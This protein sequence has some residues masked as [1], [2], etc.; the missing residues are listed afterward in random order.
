[1]EYM[2]SFEGCARR[3]VREETGIE[4]ENVRF[5]RLMNLKAYAPRHYVDI[6]LTADW[7]SGEPRALE[8]DRVELW[9]W[10]RIDNLPSP[11]FASVLT[12]IEALKI[13]RS[14]WDA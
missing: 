4:I 3:E 11:L 6:G 7:K 8:P 10:Y 13:G 9:K 1:M 14:F 12:Y 5:L 2:E